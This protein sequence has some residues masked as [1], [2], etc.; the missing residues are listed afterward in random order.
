MAVTQESFQDKHNQLGPD[1]LQG[2]YLDMRLLE[3]H[4]KTNCATVIEMSRAVL[5]IQTPAETAPFEDNLQNFF[6]SE[7]Y[8][9]NRL[10]YLQ[11]CGYKTL[12]L[13]QLV[14]ELETRIYSYQQ[15]LTLMQHRQP[16]S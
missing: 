8:F 13:W 12:K 11:S 6:D 10:A 5:C 2:H 9:E 15:I 4:L 1:S 3:S 14:C 7:R 16:A